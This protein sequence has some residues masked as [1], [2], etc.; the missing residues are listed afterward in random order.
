MSGFLQL[1]IMFYLAVGLLLFVL[2]VF[3]ELRAKRR[4]LSE[5]EST[6]GDALWLTD[7]LLHELQMTRSLIKQGRV[8]AGM[9]RLEYAISR[10]ERA[11]EELEAA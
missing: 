11:Q 3:L 2:D 7:D 1:I 9:E 6:I 10:L 5:T 8:A 4:R